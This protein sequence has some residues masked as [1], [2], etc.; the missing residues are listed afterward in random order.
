MK[1]CD[2]L[3]HIYC[4][5]KEKDSAYVQAIYDEYKVTRK[6]ITKMKRESKIDYYRIYFEANKNKTSSI[7]KGINQF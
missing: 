2:K 6:S 1:K 5:A 3:L 7:W 4:K